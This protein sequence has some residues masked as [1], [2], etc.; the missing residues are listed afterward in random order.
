MNPY[1][2]GGGLAAIALLGLL[3]KNSYERN[4]ELEALLKTQANETLECTD[5]NT[6]NQDT[7]TTL[8]TRI[9]AMI[10]ERR[11]DTERREQVLV[12]REAELARARARADQL[13]EERENEQD[14]NQ[15]CADLMSLS[16]DSFCPATAHQLRQRTIGASGDGD[17]DSN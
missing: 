3:L 8:E 1:V 7:I 4:G 6:T 15:D 14:S 10:E 16:L 5:A 12:E 11:V 17:A 13:E 9:A 2:I